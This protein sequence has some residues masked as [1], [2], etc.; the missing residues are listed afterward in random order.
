MSA[1]FAFLKRRREDLGRNARLVKQGPHDCGKS[2]PDRRNTVGEEREAH[3][4][5]REAHGDEVEAHSFLD[6][7][8]ND[9]PNLEHDTDEG[10]D[11]EGHMFSDRPNLDAP[12]ND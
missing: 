11:V 5:E 7:P 8:N 9:S 6:A 12:N 2:N 10:A 4:D 3:G 1:A